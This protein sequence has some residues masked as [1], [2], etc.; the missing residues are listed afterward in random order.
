MTARRT[1][2][3]LALA[4][5]A[6][7]GAAVSAAEVVIL[8]DG[9]VIQGNV[10]KEVETV[11]D[12]AS[13]TSVRMAK[14]NGL[15]MIDE[16]PKVMIFSTHAKQLG[17]IAPDIKLRPE[18]KAY[19]M[20]FT[21][22]K[23]DHPLTMVTGTLKVGEFNAKWVR[24]LKVGT[25]GGAPGPL[26]Q[27]ITHMDPYMIYMVSATH[28]WRLTYRTSEWDPKL[29]RKLLAM[30]PDLN[31]PDGKCVPLRRIAIAKFMLDAGWLQLAKDELDRL[32]RDF[33]GEMAMADKT[34]LDK[35]TKE[36]E[37]ATAELVVREAEQALAAGRYEYAA[38]LLAVFPEK[39]AEPK[40]VARAAKVGAD[41][42]TSRERYEAGRRLLTALIDDV[43][44]RRAANPLLAAGGGAALATWRPNREVPAPTLELAAAAGQVAA[45]LHPDSALRIETFVTLATQAERQRAAGV[46]PTKKPT[47]LIATAI[48]G[49]AKG[50][51]GAT[52]NV[53]A[54]LKLWT[55]RA[56]ILAYQRA[57]TMNARNDILGR[58][59]RTTL[60][61]DEVAQLISLLPPAE[62][63]DL[64]HRSGTPVQIGKGAAASGVYRRTTPPAPG[65]ATGIDYLVKLPPEYDHGR[66]YPVLVV[67]THAGVDAEVV[68]APLLAEADKNGYILIAPEWAGQFN[69]GGWEWRGEDHLYATAALRGRGAPLHGGQR[70]RVPVR[71]RR[72]REHGDGRG[73]VAPGPVRRGGGDGADPEVARVLHRVLA[74][75]AEAAVLRR[76]RRDGRRLGHQ[77]Q[78]HLRE[79]DALR[80][81]GGDG[82]VQ[83]PRGRVV[84][85]RDAGRLR[86]DEPQEAGERRRH[87]G[88]RHPPPPVDDAA[89]GRQPLLLAPGRRDRGGPL[90]RRA[91]PG[92][93]DGRHPRQQPDRPQ[94][95]RRDPTHRV[96]ER[97]H[98]RLDEPRAGANQLLRPARVQAEEDHAR[99]RSA[100]RR[101]LRPRRPPHAVPE[102]DR[103]RK[104]R[105]LERFV[106]TPGS[107]RRLLAVGAQ[108][109]SFS[110]PLP[111]AARNAFR[112][113]ASSGLSF[114]ASRCVLVFR[115]SFNTSLP[116]ARSPSTVAFSP[117][118]SYCVGFA[119]PRRPVNHT[120]SASRSFVLSR[121]Q[122]RAAPRG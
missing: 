86:L 88:P 40:E 102:Q 68:L 97:G 73:R 52:P 113:S 111:N 96:A 95:P 45:E 20:K 53:E 5:F 27:Q 12:K 75:R 81:P 89:R 56:T 91:G 9:F 43:T 3:A 114:A 79:V 71:R 116:S 39:T 117:K 2:T 65:Y 18:Y 7:C 14:A 115:N 30:H 50:R 105:A 41:L 48:S 1:R 67:L 66:A 76:H 38:E 104:H 4:L 10:H 37:Q 77:P 87:A 70:P 119:A 98:D 69:K 121:A 24:T 109:A 31:E 46:E 64:L 35:I 99:P 22:R 60:G 62:P 16:G 63:E 23:S 106:H 84:R 108:P 8:K 32:K 100:A 44:G 55:A 82:G 83:G 72:R 58:F 47:E 120:S 61:A 93:D 15:D 110:L 21:G 51:N 118:R 101:L 57:D 25:P 33:D 92:R 103:P 6:G 36:I 90:R 59:K 78:A 94:V 112:C 74:E 17:A 26:D 49:W 11:F 29:V 122:N 28:L 13:G 107:R 34:A 80:V 54:A 85:G 19:T 42:K